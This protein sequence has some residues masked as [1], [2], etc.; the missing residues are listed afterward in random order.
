MADNSP[1]FMGRKS[2]IDRNREVV[3]PK[4]GFEITGPNVNMWWLAAFI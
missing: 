3:K 4:F 2:R 1:D